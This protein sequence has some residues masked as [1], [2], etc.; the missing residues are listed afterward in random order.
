MSLSSL[1]YN[2]LSV[3]LGNAGCLIRTLVS[4]CG[5]GRSGLLTG[6]FVDGQTDTFWEICSFASV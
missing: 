6:S 5:D 3:F 4:L 1:Q 2:E